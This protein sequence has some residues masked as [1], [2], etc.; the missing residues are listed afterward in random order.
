MIIL[1]LW[2]VALLTT[3]YGLPLG[4]LQ[5]KEKVQ[6]EH[7]NPKSE[8]CGLGPYRVSSTHGINSL[9]QA[10]EF[11]KSAGLDLA[12]ISASNVKV[13]G[14]MLVTCLGPK[15]E[16]WIKTGPTL[17]CSS[18]RLWGNGEWSLRER[19]KCRAIDQLP[20]ICIKP[21]VAKKTSARQTPQS[22]I[23]DRRRSAKDTKKTRNRQRKRQS[24]LN[25]QSVKPRD[26]ARDPRTRRG[27]PS[28]IEKPY[29]SKPYR[30]PNWKPA[31]KQ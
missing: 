4:E 25:G 13:V 19:K 7:G 5:P 31:D 29:L 2:G 12:S 14:E 10:E 6:P 15:A 20:A 9:D 22:R 1:G 18:L 23:K 26:E 11:C 17:P 28:A 27:D 16:A 24:I 8:V 3:V 21:S 30:G